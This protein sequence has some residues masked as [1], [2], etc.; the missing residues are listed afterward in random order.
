MINRLFSLIVLSI[1]VSTFNEEIPDAFRTS[2][3]NAFYECFMKWRLTM[4]IFLFDIAPIRDYVGY[5][6]I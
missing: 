5:R 4:V 6:V 3:I 1:S 2:I